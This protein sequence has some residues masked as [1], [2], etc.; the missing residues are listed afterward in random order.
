MSQVEHF[1]FQ[2]LSKPQLL[3]ILSEIGVSVVEDDLANPVD[4]K[5]KQIFEK[6]IEKI[7]N[8][9]REDYAQVDFYAAERLENPEL[10]DDSVPMINFYKLCQKLLATAGDVVPGT[11]EVDFGLHDLCRPDKKRLR[12][13]LSAVGNFVMFMGDK[14]GT[15]IEMAERTGLLREQKEKLEAECARLEKL[16]K[17][18]LERREAEKPLAAQLEA[19]NA[20]TEVVLSQL[21]EQENQLHPKKKEAKRQK[22]EAADALM[23]VKL[24]L[25]NAAEERDALRVQVVPDSRKL[26][27]DLAALQSGVQAAR[28]D[29]RTLELQRAQHATQVE[30]LERA[31]TALDE[32]LSVQVECEAEQ[33]RVKETQRQLRECTER[34][35]RT[36]A[37]KAETQHQMRAF[38]K[39]IESERA[40]LERAR[41]Q[42]AKQLADQQSAHEDARRRWSALESERSHSA[43]Q[44][45][46]SGAKLRD[47][48]E[49]LHRGKMDHETIVQQMVQQQNQLAGQVRALPPGSA[50]RDERPACKCS[51]RRPLPAPHRCA[52]TTRI[53]SPRCDR[54]S[55]RSRCRPSP[56]REGGPAGAG[57]QVRAGRCGPAGEDRPA[58]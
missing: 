4:W 16:R 44:L 47:V 39:R 56:S 22:E 49:R 5:V 54:S 43:L 38:T 21:W 27:H 50:R 26:K 34:A 35:T 25:Q 52:R 46:E 18:L 8:K 40:R 20:N 45:D 9:S 17:E 30:T 57:R 24:H 31:E 23:E 42:Q 15:F 2:L 7:L 10:H 53:C 28:A 58:P 13:H 55:T 32:A 41:E 12:Q 14:E 37:E 48:R 11:S 51:R 19:E 3:E 29:V 33:A 6:L 36:D 1:T